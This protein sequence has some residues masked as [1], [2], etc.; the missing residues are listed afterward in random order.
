V[1]EAAGGAAGAAPASS[2]GQ[3]G[4]STGQG[5]ESGAPAGGER[6][7]IGDFS[8]WSGRTETAPTHQQQ[9]SLQDP[10][11]VGRQQ[12]AEREQQSDSPFQDDGYDAQA[13]ALSVDDSMQGDVMSTEAADRERADRLRMHDEWL[14]S[15]D[16][17]EPFQQKFV[18][19][20]IDGQRYRIP[21]AEA[22]AGYQR[23]VDYSNK[24]R[25]VYQFEA[26]LKQQFQGLQ[27]LLA[28]LDDGQRFIDAMVALK[29]FPGFHRAAVIYGRQLAAEQAMTP[30]Q[31]AL[32]VRERALRAQNQEL[33]MQLTQVMQQ[34][35][36]VQQQQ[37]PQM[38]KDA[39]VIMNQLAQMWPRAAQA[40]GWID[41]PAALREF[42]GHWDN[43]FPSLQGREVSTEFV[44]QVMRS[45][46]ES[47]QAHL[48]AGNGGQQ[49]A[50]MP[51]FQ[52][53]QRA[54]QPPGRGLP[55]PAP[56]SQNGNG[57][58]RRARIGD[59]ST[60]VGRRL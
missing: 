27:A 53:Q 5:G 57:M 4:Q 47:I 16:L 22:V 34:F 48:A 17:A 58:Q 11:L 56:S 28:D 6:G 46:M 25:S 39:Q 31:R 35:Q 7:R 18:T 8:S 1:A 36:Q 51:P 55:G 44:A 59:L 60:L 54:P 41:S 40:V 50:A 29:K 20:T 12:V 19:A 38:A 43:L 23:N 42:E 26:R 24:L 13:Q 10:S 52:Q 32:V 33:Q 49:A 2:G 15:D 30:E 9:I 3:A 37:P 45:A 14:K 21:V